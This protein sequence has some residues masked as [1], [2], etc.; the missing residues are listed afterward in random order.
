MNVLFLSMKC[1][2]SLDD[3]NIY[4]DLVKEFVSHGHHVDVLCPIEKRYTFSDKAVN[5]KGFNLYY[6]HVGNITDTPFIEKGIAVVQLGKSINKCIKENIGNNKIDVF[7][8]AAAPVTFEQTVR[9][10]K[11]RYSCKVYLLL[12]DIWPASMFDLNVPGGK[13]AKVAVSKVFRY[14]EKRLY[15]E[16]DKIGCL[17]QA[18][19]EYVLKHNRYLPVNKVEVNPNSILPGAFNRL[20][21][22]ERNAVRTQYGIPLDKVCF[23]YGGSLGIGQ[24]IFHVVKC[25]RACK[26]IDCHFVISGKGMQYP[27][28]KEYLDNEKPTNFT[29]ING[30]PQREYEQ[31]MKSCDVGMVFLRFTAQTA[32]IP[33]RILGYMEAGLPIL[34][35]TD[36]VS[37]LNQ[38]IEKGRFGWGCLSNDENMFKKKII[39]AMNLDI[40]EY[41]MNS[42]KYLEENFS[43][44]DS[45]KMIEKCC[46]V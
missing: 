27:L 2:P 45:F 1:M 11:K 30:L 37:D 3:S 6:P 7:I 28:L 24:N 31:L 15:K 44:F 39:E 21:E 36:P 14:W 13:L 40:S 25:L 42:R 8:V 22:E 23:I 41:G 33:S 43:V 46:E 12:K 18:N 26:E 5:G 17:S 34:S 32:N 4:S 29:L 20:S 10:V 38:I 9:Y 19:V 16:V 35:C